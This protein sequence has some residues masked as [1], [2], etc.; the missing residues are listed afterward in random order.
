MA[1]LLK[2]YYAKPFID[3][4]SQKLKRATKD[5]DQKRFEKLILTESWS[6]LA[7]KERMNCITAATNS[8]ID[9]NYVNQISILNKVAPNFKGL[10]A[11]IFPNFVEKYGL[12]DFD[13]S[14]AALHF[15][16]Q[17]SSSEFAIRP[18]LK[19]KP[20]TIN[21]LYDWSK[22][23]N[24]HVR[25]LS[26]EGCR[27][28]L[29]WAIKLE[30][31]VEDPKPILPILERL[32]DDKEDYVYR[33][34]ANNLNDISKHHPKLVLDLAKKWKNNSDSANWV[35]K[36]GLRTLLKQGNPD[37]MNLFGFGSVKDFKISAFTIENSKLK[38]GDSTQF[39]F[40]FL[41]ADRSAKFRFEYVI[42]Y[43][44]RNGKLSDKVFQL[45]EKKVSNGELVKFT[46]KLNFA[47]LSTRKHYPGEHILSLKVNGKIVA[48][49]KFTL[50]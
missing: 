7:L 27:P 12:H 45:V 13:T 9:L 50:E 16:T 46:R 33:S 40:S 25:R 1:E 36:H 4:L 20:E 48:K 37:A 47:D 21:V 32:K 43:L 42:S 24:F 23:K 11:M 6:S 41:N 44:K 18:F 28:L 29:P 19:S 34:V 8:C 14:L 26:S 31:Y 10:T 2:N 39:S 22:D 15:Y 35:I 3:E 30:Q 5:F 17:F 38:I 49:Q